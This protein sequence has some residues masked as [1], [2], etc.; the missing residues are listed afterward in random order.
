[1]L[2]ALGIFSGALVVYALSRTGGPW[3]DPVSPI[4]GHGL[5]H[6][7]AAVA[8]AFA[9]EATGASEKGTLP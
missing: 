7:M 2:A 3:C 4:Q 1:M 9:G 5:W 8:L 6:L